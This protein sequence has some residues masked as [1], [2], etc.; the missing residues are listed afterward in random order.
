MD[1]PEIRSQPMGK[2]TLPPGLLRWGRDNGDRIAAVLAALGFALSFGFD[3]G[4]DNQL[5]YLLRSLTIANPGI[6]E[7][8][9]FASQTTHYHPVFAYFGALL[10][11]LDPS[12]W[13]V[14]LV[15]IA[16]ITAGIA[17]VYEMLRA[18]GSRRAALAAFFCTIA[19]VLTTRTSGVATTYVFDSLLQ[20][21]ALGSLGLL[22]GAAEFVK[23][24]YFASG[25]WLG[26]GGLFHANYLVLAIPVFALA[27]LAIGLPGLVQRGIRQ[28]GP[29]AVAALT[30][31]PVML[32]AA[33]PSPDAER[34]QQ[35]L[36]EIRSPHH[37]DPEYF[38]SALVPF[39]AYQM[40]GIG[41]AAHLL[42]GRRTAAGRYGILLAALMAAVWV[43]TAFQTIVYWPRVVQIFV[44]RLAPYIDL[45]SIA[46]A[47][48]VLVELAIAPATVRRLSPAAMG[49]ALAGLVLL[50]TFGN[51]R[52]NP[53][54]LLLAFSA[55]AFG[56]S[57]LGLLG[58]RAKL[59]FVGRFWRRRGAWVVLG[60]SVAALSGLPSALA[61]TRERSSLLSDKKP[62][63]ML[64]WMREHTAADAVFLTPPDLDWIRYHGRRAIVVD[65]KAAPMV[66]SE[67]VEWHERLRDVTGR[68]VRSRRDL[69]GY[70]QLNQ[71][72]LR[73]LTE[74]YGLSYVIVRR[75]AAR[76]LGFE[77][78][79]AYEDDRFIVYRL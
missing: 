58:E 69:R 52:R 66:P 44:Y 61:K 40:L 32:A 37:Y 53:F 18:L 10:L 1:P 28:L 25:I 2:L 76:T 73:E 41:L 62:N 43:G 19:V 22:A 54:P 45:F 42:R 74:K 13:L 6:L 21:S 64:A 9:W 67:L 12:G 51:E 14:A 50:G 26:V 33:A 7:N 72:R 39:A 17:M 15:Q 31:L 34:A 77:R 47:C 35:I 60:V 57:A 20:P 5:V 55:V 71:K 23:G 68:E 56:L 16:I 49:L 29:L 79:P 38:R 24:R 48:F 8:D 3:Y 70:N 4:L 75:E 63:A 59:G 78:A 65:W 30:L 36:F 27:Q 46:I 11:W